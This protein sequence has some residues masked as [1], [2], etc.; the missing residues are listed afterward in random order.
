VSK[1]LFLGMRSDKVLHDVY[2]ELK[3]LQSLILN[4]MATPWID[5]QKYFGE[6][7]ME[8]R[9]NI[10]EGCLRTTLQ[11]VPVEGGTL[12]IP[13]I[14]ESLCIA[15]G[16][17]RDGVLDLLQKQTSLRLYPYWDNTDAPFDVSPEEW[18]RRRQDWSCCTFP[19]HRN[20]VQFLLSE[21]SDFIKLEALNARQN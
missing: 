3:T 9:R 8:Q 15:L 17:R 6:K 11:L 12:A 13:S 18:E 5:P 10:D 20:G 1:K 4:V 21:M 14:D 7:A 19:E 2:G 16:M